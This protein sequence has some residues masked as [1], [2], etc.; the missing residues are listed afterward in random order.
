MLAMETPQWDQV[1]SLFPNPSSLQLRAMLSL[2]DLSSLASVT[3]VSQV[4][5]LRWKGW[6]A[7]DRW[8]DGTV[9]QAHWIIPRSRFDHHW[10][11]CVW[12]RSKANGAC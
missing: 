11:G 9:A 1:A 3:F 7:I 4:M 10:K 5:T 8:W 6:R 12:R 2:V